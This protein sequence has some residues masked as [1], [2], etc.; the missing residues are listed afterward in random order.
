MK[1]LL[2]NGADIEARNNQGETVLFLTATEDFTHSKPKIEVAKLL[3]DRGANIEA[4]NNEGTT[5]LLAAVEAHQELVQLLL[6]K[7]ANIEA[8]NEDGNTLLMLAVHMDAHKEFVQ[9]LLDKGVDIDAKDKAGNTALD[10]AKRWKHSALADL[11]EQAGQKRKQLEE[12]KAKDPR[13]IFASNLRAYQQNPKDEALRE[14]VILLANS[15][16]E[17]PPIPEAARQLFVL[18]SGQ[19]KQATTPG[20]LD[21]PI[22]LLRKATDLAPWWGNAYY[23]LSRA[24]E[25]SGQYDE[26][27]QQLNYYLELK[28]VEADA[29]EAQA[30]IVVIQTEKEAA[31]HKQP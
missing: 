5:V 13:T 12:A 7:G 30:H 9:M 26:A 16:P 31:A 22:V 1:F 14:I 17:P 10:L 15:L 3:L 21:Q 11:L 6:D 25:M 29:S 24:L 8:R 19:I 23:N 2:D 28:P 27:I 18:A 20:A 4:R